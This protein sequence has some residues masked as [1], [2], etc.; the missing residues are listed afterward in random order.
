MYLQAES[1]GYYTAREITS[2]AQGLA[3]AQNPTII[4]QVLQLFGDEADFSERYNLYSAHTYFSYNLIASDVMADFLIAASNSSSNWLTFLDGYFCYDFTSYCN[5]YYYLQGMTRLWYTDRRLEHFLRVNATVVQNLRNLNLPTI[6]IAATIYYFDYYY[7]N[8]LLPANKRGAITYADMTRWLYDEYVPHGYT[9]WTAQL[10]HTFDPVQYNVFIR[11]Y[12]PSSYNY[13]I[14]KNFTYDAEVSVSFSD[15]LSFL[16][17]SYT[18][19]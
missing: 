8:V 6:F 2:I 11:P 4:A 12:F 18:L 10:N 15:F 14:G 19:L 13:S 1:T 5:I 16:Q 9:P 17:Y 3:C 7:N